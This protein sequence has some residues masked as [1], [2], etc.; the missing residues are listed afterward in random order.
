MVDEMLSFLTSREEPILI[1]FK[2]IRNRTTEHIDTEMLAGHIR[3]SLIEKKIYFVQMNYRGE[4]I[5]EIALGQSGLV[6]ETAVPIGHLKSPNYFLEG[7]ITD[8]VNYEKNRSI[9]YLVV[10]LN[11]TRVRSG[12]MVWTKNQEFLKSTRNQKVGW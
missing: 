11:L 4:I 9:Q 12:V 5:Q 1:A 7:V 10:T 8:T 3:A 6:D 2:P